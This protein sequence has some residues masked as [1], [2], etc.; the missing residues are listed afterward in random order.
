MSEMPEIGFEQK[1][2]LGIIL[3]NRPKALNA[4]THEMAIALDQKLQDWATDPSIS[5]VLIKGAGEK[6]FCAGGDVVKLYQEGKAGGD[7]PYRFYHDEYVCN[8]RVKHFPKPYIAFIDG[9]VMG[10]GVGVSVHGSHRIATEKTLFAMPETGIG[11]FPD[12]GGTYFLPRCPG[13]VGMYLGLTGQRLKAADT[14]YAGVANA[15]VESAKLDALEAELSAKAYSDNAHEDVSAIIAQFESDPGPAGLETMKLMIDRH[16]CASSVKEIISGLDQEDDEWAVR[17]VKDLKVKSPTSL[18]LTF[19]QIREG[20]TK[21]FD[22]CMKLEWRMV[23][24]VIKG[25]D[26]YEGVRALLVDKDQK[27]KWSPAELDK[28]TD[29]DINVYFD[30]LAAGDLDI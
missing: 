12:V 17:T 10:G 20:A 16:F 21:S 18:Q 8:A 3:L 4:L 22:E 25:V 19:R 13:E 9:I 11:L 14:I 30:P 29:E 5:A 24:R 2:E 26:F 7:Y 15:Y 6:A 1:G 23:N 28:V 27:P